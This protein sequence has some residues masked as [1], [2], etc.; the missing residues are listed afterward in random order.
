MARRLCATPVTPRLYSQGVG[1]V[2]LLKIDVE[3]HELEA[4][5]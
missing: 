3:G 5:Q 1:G 4:P 2:A